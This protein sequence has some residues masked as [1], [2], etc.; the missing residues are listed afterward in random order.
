MRRRLLVG[1]MASARSPRGAVVR[2]PL[3]R[4]LVQ[5][6]GDLPRDA[7]AGAGRERVG[8]GAVQAGAAQRP[9]LG[10]R[11]L[12]DERVAELQTGAGRRAAAAAFEELRRA[13]ARPPRPSAGPSPRRR[14]VATTAAA[15]R[16]NVPPLYPSRRADRRR[17]DTAERRLLR[18]RDGALI[19]RYVSSGRDGTGFADLFELGT[20]VTSSGP[21]RWCWRSSAAGTWRATSRSGGPSWRPAAA[22]GG[23]RT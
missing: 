19:A 17:P 21:C 13:A 22:R 23:T 8:R 10:D 16:G 18:D 3:V 7:P 1:D 5:V 15:S 14:C 12:P 2:G 20:G 11:G 6:V 4:R 9:E